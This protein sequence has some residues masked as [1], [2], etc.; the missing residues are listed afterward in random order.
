MIINLNKQDVYELQ[1]YEYGTQTVNNVLNKLIATHNNDLDFLNSEVY[2]WLHEKQL[3]FYK[4][5]VEQQN[6]ILSPYVNTDEFKSAKNWRIDY[7]TH[8]LVLE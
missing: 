6:K 4:M 1:Y 5:K 8:T 3:A 7:L 2:K